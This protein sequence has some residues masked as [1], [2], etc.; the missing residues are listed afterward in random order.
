MAKKQWKLVNKV[1]K[2]KLDGKCHFCPVDDYACLQLH[3]ILPGEDDGIYS[4]FNTITCCANCHN[5]IH[6]GQIVIDRKY[7][8][9]SARWVVHFW[10]HGEEKW[11]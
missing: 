8:T 4:D 9:S 6:D 10:E 2:K 7:F 3:R 5:K 1:A 11:L